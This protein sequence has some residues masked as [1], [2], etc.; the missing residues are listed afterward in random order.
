MKNLLEWLGIY[1]V[2]KGHQSGC[3][4][5]RSDFVARTGEKDDKE[6]EAFCQFQ[7]PFKERRPLTH[8]DGGE[9]D[10]EYKCK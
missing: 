10:C 1:G 3:E 9:S 4:P 2:L 7:P 5:W 8:I 6:E